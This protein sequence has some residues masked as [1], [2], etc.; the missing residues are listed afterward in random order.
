M[1]KRELKRNKKQG[2]DEQQEFVQQIIEVRRVTRVMAGG[3][4]M[5]FRACVVLGDKAGR[6]GYGVGKGLDVTSAVQ[7]ATTKAKAQM[8][9]VPLVGNTIP[10]EVR[11]K[12]KA[13]RVLLKPAPSGTGV[14][15]GGAVRFVLDLAGIQDIT[16]KILGGNNKVNNVKVA[17]EALRSLKSPE[18]GKKGQG[19]ESGTAKEKKEKSEKGK[20][21]SQ[22]KKKK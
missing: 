13:A 6:V 16:A 17:W 20:G 2:R 8:I 18:K 3:K 7:K 15:A 22:E 9:R 21:K 11:M 14:K 4:R 5:Q 12:F 10:H 1:A 19:R